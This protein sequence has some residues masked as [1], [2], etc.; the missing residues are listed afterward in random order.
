MF[1]RI[2]VKGGMSDH[3]F[4]CGSAIVVDVTITC[5][6]VGVHNA[7]VYYQF[8]VY[9]FTA[10]RHQSAFGGFDT[11]VFELQRPEVCTFTQTDKVVH[12]GR[13]D[14]QSVKDQTTVLFAFS[15]DL[16][17]E[18]QYRCSPFCRFQGDGAS[19]GDTDC[20]GIFSVGEQ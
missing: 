9:A 16:I 3:Y 19:S 7:V 10:Y 18:I 4:L 8:S 11:A 2:V 1:L 13:L 17:V 5:C 15:G 14:C 12:V 20:F 6:L